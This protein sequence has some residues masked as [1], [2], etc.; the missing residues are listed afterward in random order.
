LF[1][2]TELRSYV[3]RKIRIHW[4]PEQIVETLKKEY[5]GNIRM[6]ISHEAIYQYIYVLP[7][8]ALKKSLIEGLRQERAWR[9]PKYK[10]RKNEEMRGK[11]ADMLSIEERPAEVAER[12]I[13]GHWEGDLIV[14]KYKRSALGTLVERTTRFTVLVPLKKKDATSVREA[15]TKAFAQLPI[16]LARSLTYDQGKEMSE[17]KQFTID[18]GMTVYFA[19][20]GSPWERGTNENTNGL[21]RRFFPKGTEFDKVPLRDIRRAQ[22]LLNGRPRKVLQFEK[23][24]EAFTRLVALNR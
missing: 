14:G 20:P 16:E 9:R 17:H 18:T 19:H 10:G 6:Q 22:D 12:I 3:E 13:P 8:G 21:I 5:A 23:P 11:I 7:R 24:H 4:S 2:N 1:Q 15:Y